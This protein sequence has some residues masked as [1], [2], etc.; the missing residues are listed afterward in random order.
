MDSLTQIALGAS[1]S[2]AVMGRRTAVWKAALWGGVAGTLPDLDVLVDHGDAVLNMVLHRAESHAL[3][4]L[5]LVSGPLA[6]LVAR[7]HREPALTV[8]WWL[9]MALALMTHPLLDL[10]TVY[11]TQVLRPFSNEAYGVG[12]IFIIDPAYTLPLLVGLGLALSGRPI[13]WRA[14]QVAL[15]LSTAYLGWSLL[16]QALVGHQAQRDLQAAGLPSQ[17]VLVTPTPFNT[18]LWR[19]VAMDGD[20]YHE[21][22]YSFLDH[23]RPMRFA[24]FPSGQALARQHA[25]HP[26]V[27]RVARFTDGFFR[28]REE[29]GR[30]W[31]TDLR[32]GQEPGYVFH[33]DI[34]P[35]LDHSQANYP[36]ARQVS[37]R[38]DI[39]G[40]LA[41][42]W[43]RLRGADVP[44][45]GQLGLQAPPRSNTGLPTLVGSASA[46]PASRLSGL[47]HAAV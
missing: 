29:G 47:G 30:L 39:R 1:L 36:P 42:L 45:P 41:W 5:A 18:V 12:S 38:T 25:D 15:G 37:L 40:G 3:F 11:G 27:Q 35:A 9:A 28:M 33:F 34:G 32:M 43:Q 23:G 6:W 44:S 16:A 22:F 10:M 7:V 24:A 4:Y 17:V 14:N 8:R 19:V 46:A 20:S 21:G 31:L 26:Q 13:G 2:V